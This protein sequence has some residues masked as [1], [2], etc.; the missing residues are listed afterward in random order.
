MLIAVFQ[1]SNESFFLLLEALSLIG[2]NNAIASICTFMCKQMKISD[3]LYYLNKANQNDRIMYSFKHLNLSLSQKYACK[4]KTWL[5]NENISYYIL[6]ELLDHYTEAKKK[7]KIR[8]A[9]FTAIQ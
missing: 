9:K 8:S 4:I 5:I 6:N 2:A 7:C 3:M 1:L